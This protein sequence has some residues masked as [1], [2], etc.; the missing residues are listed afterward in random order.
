M[1]IVGIARDP[2]DAQLSQTI[3]LV[4]GTPAFAKRYTPNA[5]LHADLRVVE[6]RRRG[7]AGVRTRS[8][9]VRADA[10]G[11]GAPFDVTPSRDDA[12]AADH[13]SSAVATGL[14]IF[15][16]VA[17]LAGLV[18]LIPLTRRSLG[19]SDDESAILGA[20]GAPRADRALAQF[21]ANLPFLVIGT[22]VAV[23]LAYLVSPLFPLGATRALEPT[24]GL[25][26]DPL[27]L[28]VGGA[29]WFALLAR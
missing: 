9:H 13:S 20:L 23:L 22:A 26:A 3:K 7:R 18:T 2:S 4:F 10:S 24:P 1:R 17:G 19:S 6:G 27:V 29:I 12:V 21:V 5:D 25:R 8:R 11:D 16:L 14:S 28:A 15:A